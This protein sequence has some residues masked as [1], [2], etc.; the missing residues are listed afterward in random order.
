MQ[1]IFI[2][3]FLVICSLIN[4]FFNFFYSIFF[5]SFNEYYL[6]HLRIERSTALPTLSFV[7]TLNI[8]ISGLA[9]ECERR[10]QIKVHAFN[11]N[12]SP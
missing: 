7:E 4:I 9:F 12:F 5:N 2:N 10:Y 3:Y 6:H 11:T 8:K 1:Y